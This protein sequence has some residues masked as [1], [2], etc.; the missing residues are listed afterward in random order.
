MLLG[1]LYLADGLPVGRQI[2]VHLT[3]AG[4]AARGVGDTQ[5]C[6]G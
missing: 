5:A 2:P 4:C 3:K 1:L 6:R